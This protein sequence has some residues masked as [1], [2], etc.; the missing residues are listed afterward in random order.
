M[1]ILLLGA[2]RLIPLL[3]LLAPVGEQTETFTHAPDDGHK[4]IGVSTVDVDG[5]LASQLGLEPGTALA[6]AEL[7]P[8]LPAADVLALHDVIV[9]VDGHEPVTRGLLGKLVQSHAAGD[10]VMLR[11]LRGG[12]QLELAVPVASVPL[13]DIEREAVDRAMAA[14][15]AVRTDNENLAQ[16]LA[17]RGESSRTA[18][19][20][21]AMKAMLAA[22]GESERV[23]DTLI[24][25]KELLARVSE[26]SDAVR[27]E[28]AGRQ[29]DLQRFAEK[30]QALAALQGHEG[31]ESQA[32]AEAVQLYKHALAQSEQSHD[33]MNGRR[34]A[35]RR[36]E[37]ALAGLSKQAAG[38]RPGLALL[39][40]VGERR[41]LV[42][43]PGLF[44]R[45]DEA[46]PELTEVHERLGRIEERLAH[47]EELL[48]AG[49]DELH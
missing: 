32:V 8:G 2:L 16:M 12:E 26:D 9:A 38:R 37:E 48:S 18:E 22:R 27:A 17:E 7:S 39:G 25:M 6:V 10:A 24:S 11:V 42:L 36:L 44:G 23:A 5:A 43:P 46:S 3:V 49:R 20:V 13:A 14:A 45:D 33:V 47:I 41:S 34:D 31:K 1:L 35:M 40:E 15:E 21:A 4:L 29:A 30:A 19:T 28:L